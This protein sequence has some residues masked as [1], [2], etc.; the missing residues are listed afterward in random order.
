[1][2]AG[3]YDVVLTYGELT[4]KHSVRIAAGSERR[5]AFDDP[6]RMP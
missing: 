5:I 1:M 2:P 6:D 4:L 3:D